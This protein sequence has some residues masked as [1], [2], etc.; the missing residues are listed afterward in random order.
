MS[1]QNFDNT[2]A[3]WVLVLILFNSCSMNNNISNIENELKRLN[4]QT[5]VIKN[6]V[7]TNSR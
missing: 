6:D 1:C 7:E 4:L 3:F 2:L 5:E